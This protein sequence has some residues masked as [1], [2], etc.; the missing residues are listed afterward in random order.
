MFN[1]LAA[2]KQLRLEA[3]KRGIANPIV[4]TRGTSRYAER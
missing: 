4:S 2:E 3:W 1:D